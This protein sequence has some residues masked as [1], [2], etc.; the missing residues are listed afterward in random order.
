MTDKQ[1][2][3]LDYLK[4]HDRQGYYI[5][6]RDAIGNHFDDEDDFDNTLYQLVAL[7]LVYE[8]DNDTLYKL[9]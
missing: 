5:D 1:N 3:I 9:R 8:N 6:I 2:L 4:H 7:D